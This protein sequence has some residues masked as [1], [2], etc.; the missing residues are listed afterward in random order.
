MPKAYGQCVILQINTKYRGSFN[1][2]SEFPEF[3]LR[4][5]TGVKPRHQASNKI[6]RRLMEESVARDAA[7]SEVI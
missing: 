6:V 1:P 7:D 4:A 2:N 3:A 5:E